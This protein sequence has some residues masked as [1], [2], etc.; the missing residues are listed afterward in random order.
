MKVR[1]AP[2]SSGD[3]SGS[4]DALAEHHRRVLRESAPQSSAQVKVADPVL[5]TRRTWNQS[6]HN[7]AR[8]GPLGITSGGE[9]GGVPVDHPLQHPASALALRLSQSCRLR[10]RSRTRQRRSSRVVIN[11]CPSGSKARS[12]L[13]VSCRIQFRH[14][15]HGAW[16]T[17][18]RP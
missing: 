15:V 4:V 18:I 14:V 12:S 11:P 16:C 17:P 8:P 1:F 6:S 13:N 5:L 7:T 10:N 9:A 2:M 3:A